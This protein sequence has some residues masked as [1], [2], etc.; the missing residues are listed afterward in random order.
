MPES[1]PETR[2]AASEFERAAGQ[3]RDESLVAELL[4]FLAHNK[5]WWMVPL[6]LVMLFLGLLLVLSSSAVAPFIYTLF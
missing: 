4:H 2:P 1:K 3:A 5:K 6:L